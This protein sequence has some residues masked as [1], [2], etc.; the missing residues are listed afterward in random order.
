M[1]QWLLSTLDLKHL[2]LQSFARSSFLYSGALGVSFDINLIGSINVSV[3]SVCPGI[4]HAVRRK[5]LQ[6]H[7]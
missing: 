5:P 4:H 2:A 3:V 1:C 6:R 7:H